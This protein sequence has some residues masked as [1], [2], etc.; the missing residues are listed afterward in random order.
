MYTKALI[1]Y[2]FYCRL[3][4]CGGHKRYDIFPKLVAMQQGMVMSS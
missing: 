3:N 1:S 2:S 4:T